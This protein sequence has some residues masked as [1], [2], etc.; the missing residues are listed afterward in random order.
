MKKDF[1]KQDF[2]NMLRPNGECLEWT[3]GTNGPGYG[4]TR[5]NG[6]MEGAHRVALQLEGFN[7]IGTEKYVLH[8]CDNPRCCNPKHLRLGDHRENMK[9]A[10]KRHRYKGTRH[11]GAK[12]TNNDINEVRKLYATGKYTQKDIGD[13]FNVHHSTIHLIVTRKHWSHL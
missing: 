6:K 8:S 4:R 7:V 3:G 10:V 2:Y 5:I 1:T 11:H 9:D 13:M 12:F